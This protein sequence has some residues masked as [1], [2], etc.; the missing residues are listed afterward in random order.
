MSIKKTTK[1]LNIYEYCL[2]VNGPLDRGRSS[3]S[4]D[5]LD[6]G[7]PIYSVIILCHYPFQI[8][9]DHSLWSSQAIDTPSSSRLSN[10]DNTCHSTNA[11]YKGIK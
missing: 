4:V 7:K 10:D 3:W 5:P 9:S 6:F 2:K 8:S 1:V 11:S